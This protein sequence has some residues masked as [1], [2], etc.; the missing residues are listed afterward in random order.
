MTKFENW[1]YNLEVTQ[2]LA[3]GYDYDC[4]WL[5]K[6]HVTGRVDSKKLIQSNHT[7]GYSGHKIL[8]SDISGKCL[9]D[10]LRTTSNHS[11]LRGNL[12]GSLLRKGNVESSV[13]ICQSHLSSPIPFVEAAWNIWQRSFLGKIIF[14]RVVD[15]LE[16]EIMLSMGTISILSHFPSSHI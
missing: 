8:E 10:K 7:H 14:D 9:F 2:H 1:H 11:V 13:L 4:K 12:T 6:G 15:V 5:F 3:I 16:L